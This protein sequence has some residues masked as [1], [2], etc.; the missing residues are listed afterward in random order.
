MLQKIF[1]YLRQPSTWRG[2]MAVAAAGGLEVGP[3]GAEAVQHVVDVLQA[4]LTGYG[5]INIARNEEKKQ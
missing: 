4:F 2:L 3:E 5:T 1:G